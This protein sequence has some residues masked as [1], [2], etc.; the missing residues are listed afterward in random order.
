MTRALL[1]FIALFFATSHLDAQIT[2]S[3]IQHTTKFRTVN[4]REASTKD[5]WQTNLKTSISKPNAF[6]KLDAV[7][8][9][10]KIQKLSA[11][12]TG[13]VNLHKTLGATPTIGKSFEANALTS[14]T[15][16]DNSV[17][18]N[19]NGQIVAV[20]NFS[21]AIY[22]T[23]G[24]ALLSP[25]TWNGIL[26]PS[27]PALVR[28]KFDPR[29]LYDPYKD[30]FIFC[31]LHAPVDTLRNSIV[32]GFSQ[33]SDPTQGWTIYNLNGN[34]LK[35]DAWS[36]Y[37]SMG[38]NE[39]ELFINC[40]LFGRAPNYS[41]RGTYIQQI[42]LATAYAGDPLQ[43]KTW[44]GFNDSIYITLVP[45]PDGLM[46]A[47][48]ARHMNF[49]T[50]NPS[51]D[52][53]FHLFTITDTMNAAGVNIT[54]QQYQVPYYSACADG[55]IKDPSSSNIDSIST[56]SC[57]VQ[58]AFT[59]DSIV[60]FTFSANVGGSCGIHYGRINLGPQTAEY[61]SYS[62]PGTD[63]A[64][65]AIAPLGYDNKDKNAALVYLRADTSILPEL[66]VITV[67]DNKVWSTAQTVKTG[68]SIVN[69]LSGQAERWGDYS[70]ITRNYSNTS[71]PEVWLYGCYAAHTTAQWTYG[72]R[73]GYKNWI[74]QIKSNDEPLNI[75]Q[76]SKQQQVTLYP[77]PAINMYYL[78]F[79]LDKKS[80]V[81][82][83]LYDLNGR[84]I[85]TLFEGE[86][87]ASKNDF[88]F[89]RNALSNGQYFIQLKVDDSQIIKKLI[90]VE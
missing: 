11:T 67:D 29:V 54:T 55:Y 78:E 22:D 65:P 70:G 36:D 64:Y 19:K 23:N 12:R 24:N 25:T 10:N 4:L 84:K 48:G 5:P 15:P 58:N 6:G 63:L 30:R 60:H 59:L 13:L 37:P 89:N 34:P 77:N 50:S 69:I 66:C 62:E 57:W 40:N 46:N 43:N 38:I 85:K 27:S 42:D 76:T 61:V 83:E 9:K 3:A 35:N 49:A 81:D 51:E 32:L 21:I 8:L 68:D 86:L 41:Y 52:T 33:T 87:P 75:E 26:S 73:N 2:S 74:A 80:M 90:L 16:P 82:I 20:N 79:Q 71:V 39:H 17:A 88:S 44:S 72:A 56:G 7:K 47:T 28:G 18:I 53:L 45:A 31:I 14:L 1:I